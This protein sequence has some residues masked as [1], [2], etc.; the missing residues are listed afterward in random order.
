MKCLSIRQPWA[1]LIVNGYKDVENRSWR[2]QYRGE[3][4]VHAAKG[5]TRPEYAAASQLALS[6]GI[7][8]PAFEDLERGGVVGIATLTACVS[9]SPSPWFFGKYGFVLTGA[10]PLPFKP[11]PG[12]LGFFELPG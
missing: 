2:T 1:W 7:T 10:S 9:V 8:L 3:F 6:Q 4:L 11:C 5:M 12:R